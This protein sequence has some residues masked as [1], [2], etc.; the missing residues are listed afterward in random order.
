MGQVM[1][2]G[3]RTW[4][5][6]KEFNVFFIKVSYKEF[7][8]SHTLSSCNYIFFFLGWRV[9]GRCSLRLWTS[10]CRRVV[11][12]KVHKDVKT[13]KE[14][15]TEIKHMFYFLF[16]LFKTCWTRQ[17]TVEVNCWELRPMFGDCDSHIPLSSRKKKQHRV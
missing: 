8:F 11:D 1:Q 5:E 7:S 9:G 10:T 14:R 2:P 17:Y 12:Q 6:R 4:P 3:Q 16:P 15:R 13:R